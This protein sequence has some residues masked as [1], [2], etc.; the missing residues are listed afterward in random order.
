M[1]QRIIYQSRCENI[2]LFTIISGTL[3]AVIFGI[4]LE[5][6]TMPLLGC[7]FNLS[8]LSFNFLIGRGQMW[9]DC[10]TCRSDSP[11]ENQGPLIPI[12]ETQIPQY[13]PNQ[14]IIVIDELFWKVYIGHSPRVC[15]SSSLWLGYLC[16]NYVDGYKWYVEPH[17]PIFGTYFFFIFR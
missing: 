4:P 12:G 3:G 9:W 7:I 13:L 10:W 2:S 14:T 5:N 8:I 1:C 17:W 15:I 11:T 16:I 6:G